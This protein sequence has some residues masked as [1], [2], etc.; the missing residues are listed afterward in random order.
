MCEKR[1]QNRKILIPENKQ[2]NIQ[3]SQVGQS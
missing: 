2:L 3:I 1:F